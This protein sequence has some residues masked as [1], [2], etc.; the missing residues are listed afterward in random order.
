[1]IQTLEALRDSL[2]TI[3]EVASCKI[4]LEQNISSKSYPLIRL[5]PQRIILGLPYNN[6][7]SETFIYF[8]VKKAEAKEGLE[9]VYKD[10]FAL[11]ASI[12]TKVKA[13]GHKVVETLFD[14]DEVAGQYK[15]GAM[16]VDIIGDS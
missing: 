7:T 16:R 8:G 10:L 6:R 11:E 12:M 14:E 5:V 13:A 2:A 9:A 3:S 4:G 15:I 1:M